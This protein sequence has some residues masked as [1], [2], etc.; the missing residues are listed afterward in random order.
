[1]LNARQS[2]RDHLI[3]IL[4][5]LREQVD[6]INGI[7]ELSG[8]VVDAGRQLELRAPDLQER[9][10]S[11]GLDNGRQAIHA[12]VEHVRLERNERIFQ[13]TRKLRSKNP[14]LLLGSVVGFLLLLP[15]LVLSL[16]LL[17]GFIFPFSTLA[18]NSLGQL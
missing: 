12:R 3:H 7:R 8:L 16:R 9:V 5:G 17:I 14:T 15:S 10:F 13:L 6:V 1:M 4:S 11:G 2:A 18:D